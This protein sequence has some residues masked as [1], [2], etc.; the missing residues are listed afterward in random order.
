MIVGNDFILQ[1][2]TDVLLRQTSTRLYQHDHIFCLWK[3]E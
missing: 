2:D 3:P 1:I